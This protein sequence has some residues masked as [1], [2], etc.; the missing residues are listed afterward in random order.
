MTPGVYN[1]VLIN[2]EGKVIGAGVLAYP[3]EIATGTEVDT[4]TDDVKYVTSKAIED[5][6]YVKDAYVTAAIS[7]KLDANSPITGA[8]KTKITYDADGLVTAGADAT[9]ADIADSTDK[10]YCTD[11]QKTVIGNTSGTNTGDANSIHA[12]PTLT[13]NTN[14]SASTAY[15]FKSIKINSNTVLY[16]GQ[17]DITPTSIS[18]QTILEISLAHASDF[19]SDKDASGTGMCFQI[20][21]LSGGIKANPTNNTIELE[22]I[23]DAVDL[24]S[25]PFSIVAVYKVI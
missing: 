11:A 13:N 3:S 7:G 12:T 15:E 23:S 20:F 8:T 2:A 18:T 22:F 5:S 24:S 10:R 25:R 9:T 4:G 6:S 19:S 21:G 14:I 17:V 16:S 1:N